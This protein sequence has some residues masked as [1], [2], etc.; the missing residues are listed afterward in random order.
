M[1]MEIISN[2]DDIMT[3]YIWILG[4]FTAWCWLAGVY[5]IVTGE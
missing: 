1:M 2:E 5:Y 4:I 3:W